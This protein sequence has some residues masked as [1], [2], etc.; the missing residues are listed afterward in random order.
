MTHS[1]LV[2]IG[3]HKTG[4]T[5]IQSDLFACRKTLFANNIHVPILKSPFQHGVARPWITVPDIY[6]PI[7]E[8]SNLFYKLCN[9]PPANTVYSI[10][11]SEVLCSQDPGPVRFNELEQLL[12][13]HSSNTIFYLTLRDHIELL[14]SIYMEVHVNSGREE[15]FNKPTFQKYV[16]SILINGH[17]YGVPFVFSE[18]ISSLRDQLKY[19]PLH[20]TD[21]A[22]LVKSSDNLTWS[23]LQWTDARKQLV[24]QNASKLITSKSKMTNANISISQY[25]F[26]SLLV[27]RNV[28]ESLGQGLAHASK[29][30]TQIQRLLDGRIPTLLSSQDFLR[31]EPKIISDL[32]SLEPSDLGLRLGLSRVTNFQN[33]YIDR[34]ECLRLFR[35][36]MVDP[37]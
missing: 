4:T 22:S 18:Y 34:N 28:V 14:S 30:A 36:L 3:L 21:F 24:G 8:E 9:P 27:D 23:F 5:A 11:S 13:S 16:D 7:N 2:H 31:I 37:Q 10:I 33:Y 20:V 26:A 1:F 29:F 6:Y 32:L 15:I 25:L 17:A 12:R 35:E 19:S